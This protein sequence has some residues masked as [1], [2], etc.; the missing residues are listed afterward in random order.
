[1]N[2]LEWSSQNILSVA[3]DSSL[4]FWNANNNKVIKFMDLN[5]HSIT[6]INWNDAGTHIAV[7]TT[8]GTTE[9]W[10]AMRSTKLFEVGGH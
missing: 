4:Y 8:Q 3:L 1:L 9:I 2:L 5:P 6:S 10:D 7:G